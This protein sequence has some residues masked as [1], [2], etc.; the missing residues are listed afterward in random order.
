M[1]CI[2]R[3]E[4]SLSVKLLTGCLSISLSDNAAV[5]DGGS[6]D[7]G[8]GG[9]GGCGGGGGGGGGKRVLVPARESPFES[10]CVLATCHSLVLLEGE[11]VGDPLEKV[12]LNAVDWNLSKGMVW[13]YG[14]I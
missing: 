8:G 13:A 11:L 7:R 5:S 3:F 4:C 10:Q 14:N 6:D 1:Y 2:C 9:G 12:A